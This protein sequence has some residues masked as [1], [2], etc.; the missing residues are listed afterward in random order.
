MRCLTSIAFT[1]SFSKAVEES[2]VKDPRFTSVTTV[3]W[4]LKIIFE[5]VFDFDIDLI[6]RIAENCIGRIFTRNSRGEILE[7]KTPMKWCQFIHSKG[8]SG[9]PLPN[10]QILDSQ[11]RHF[12]LVDPKEC[13]Y[14]L[15]NN[16]LKKL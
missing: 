1:R 15:V 14:K 7:V 4:C 11:N 5:N 10:S 8:P 6:Q 2:V 12:L 3:L 9:S 16:C 13:K